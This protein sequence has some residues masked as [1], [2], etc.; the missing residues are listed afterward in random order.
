M[1]KRLGQNLVSLFGLLVFGFVLFLGFYYFSQRFAAEHSVH[2][3][4]RGTGTSNEKRQASE[5]VQGRY[6]LHL[7]QSRSIGKVNF[8]YRG[9]AGNA[10]C[11][12]DVIIP[13][14]DPERPYKYRLDIGT[15]EKG[16]RMA[17]HNFKL[18]TAGKNYIRLVKTAP[19]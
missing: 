4:M 15:A 16:F 17:G 12:I 3:L 11:R 7:N 19:Q 9:L 10:V 14:L 13:D 5:A 1:E 2:N 18:E 6:V 8:V